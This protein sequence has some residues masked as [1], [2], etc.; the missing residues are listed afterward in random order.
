MIMLRAKC[1][2]TSKNSPLSTIRFT[3]SRMSYGLFGLSGT[4]VSS[5]G[6][7]RSGSSP[8]SIRGGSSRLFWGR[9]DMR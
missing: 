1:S 7:S 8:V 4:I 5:S 3:T 2:C 6:S 9:N